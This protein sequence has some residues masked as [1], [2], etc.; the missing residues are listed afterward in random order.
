MDS[1]MKRLIAGVLDRNG[2][3]QK[4][5]EPKEDSAEK[6][7]KVEEKIRKKMKQL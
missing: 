5:K 2:L 1:E 3:M 7:A 4:K 6:K